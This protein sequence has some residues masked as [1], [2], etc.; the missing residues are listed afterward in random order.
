MAIIVNTNISTGYITL[1][2]A[3]A[4]ANNLKLKL[5]T[6]DE[7]VGNPKLRI[8][9]ED[10]SDTAFQ[11]TFMSMRH[12]GFENMLCDYLIRCGVAAGLIPIGRAAVERDMKKLEQDWEER[13]KELGFR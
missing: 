9:Y 7:N 12:L 11:I 5:S 10:N 6:I 4:K 13:R 8:T 1:I 2:D 3:F